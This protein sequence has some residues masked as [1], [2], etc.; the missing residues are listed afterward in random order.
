[1]AETKNVGRGRPKK[2][3]DRKYI[4]K[5]N[6]KTPTK[7]KAQIK[8]T[9]NKR[10]KEK[11]QILHKWL[12]VVGI[13][14]LALFVFSLLLDK[15]KSKII[16]EE[17]GDIR[18]SNFPKDSELTDLQKKEM[19]LA[20][21][22]QKKIV[23][24][25]ETWNTAPIKNTTWVIFSGNEQTTVASGLVINPLDEEKQLDE[26]ENK[27]KHILEVFY[28]QLI[29][30]E[31]D[32]ASTMVDLYLKDT[33]TYK[34]YYSEDWIIDFIQIIDNDSFKVKDIQRL[35]DNMNKPNNEYYKYTLSYRVKE[36]TYT[37]QWETIII[38]RNWD[39][40]IWSFQCVSNW[41]SASPF[42]NPGK[43]K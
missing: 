43:Y 33:E 40:Q 13:F 42:F 25:I 17:Y 8:K 22:Q 32:K 29:W 12:Y 2:D 34:D 3:F 36:K 15:Y 37:E 18:I 14:I 23:N 11:Q 31:T 5:T 30:G 35:E 16:N 38:N 28:Q 26:E 6:K 20:H 4:R 1:M 24:V 9:P 39:Q 21:A 10:A 7:T 27:E 19:D 41:C